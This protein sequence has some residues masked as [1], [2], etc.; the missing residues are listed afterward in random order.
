ML[1]PTKEHGSPECIAAKKKEMDTFKQFDV[2]L[3]VEDTGQSLL[4]AEAL[5]RQ[6][7]YRRTLQQEARRHCA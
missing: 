2:Y 7:R 5:R 6:S 4:C 1:I 3:E